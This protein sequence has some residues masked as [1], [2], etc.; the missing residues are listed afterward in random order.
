MPIY[1]YRCQ[2]CNKVF[3]KLQKMGEC[4]EDL[5]CPYCGEKGPE[6]ILSMF[7]SSKSEVPTS[8]CLPAGGSSGST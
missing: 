1:E 5:L 4:G 7:T 2:K 6:K 3:E 8:S